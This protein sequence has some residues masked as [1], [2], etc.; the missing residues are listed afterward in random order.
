M[1]SLK[2]QPKAKSIRPQE[3]FSKHLVSRI[4]VGPLKLHKKK[5]ESSHPMNE[6]RNNSNPEAHQDVF[7]ELV[8]SSVA[9]SDLSTS[10]SM[11]SLYRPS[12][13]LDSDSRHSFDHAPTT[14]TK[15]PTEERES[16]SFA[17][18]FGFKKTGLNLALTRTIST[19]NVPAAKDSS[20]GTNVELKDDLA[21]D[22]HLI[23]IE[24]LEARV[25]SNVTTGLTTEQAQKYLARDGGNVIHRTNYLAKVYRFLMYFFGGFSLILWPAAIV[26]VLSYK[27]FGNPNP[28]PASLGLAIVIFGV[29][30]INAFFNAYQDYTS[31]KVMGAIGKMM[32]QTAIVIRNGATAEIPLKDVAVG[33]VVQLTNGAKVPADCRILTT[34]QLKVDASILTGEAEPI[35]CTVHHTDNNYMETK[36]LLFMGASIVEGSGTGLV[37][38][39]GNRTVMGKIYKLSGGTATATTPITR[40]LNI[41]LLIIV[42]IAFCVCLSLALAYGLWLK[43]KYPSFMSVS[44]IIVVIIGAVVGLLPD[45]LPVSITLTFSLIARKMFEHNVM[46]KNLPTVETLGSISVIASDKTGTLTQNK[47]SLMHIFLWA[48]KRFQTGDEIRQLQDADYA[49][50]EL[51]K[52]CCLCNRAQFEDSSANLTLQQRKVVGDASDTA[53][54]FFSEDL[55]RTAD[56]RGRHQKLAEIPFNSKNKWMLSIYAEPKN[57]AHADQAC[58]MFKGAPEMVIDRCSTI[59]LEDGK[60]YELTEALREKIA[61]EQE[62]LSE[63]GERVLGLSCTYLDRDKYPTTYSFDTEAQNFPM[64]G[65]CF[66]GLV[67]LIDPPRE[68]V[69]DAVKDC[70]QAGIRVMMVTGDHPTTAV[71]IARMVGIVTN[72]HVEAITDDESM[73]RTVAHCRNKKEKKNYLKTQSAVV[74]GADIPKFGKQTW[75]D[76]LEFKEIVFARTTPEHKLKIVQEYQKKKHVVAAIG[77]GVNDSPALKQSNVGVAMGSGSDIAREAADIVLTNSKFSSIVAG[78]KLGRVA[79]DNLKKVLIYMLP[80]GSFSELIPVLSNI[81]LGLPT[82]LSSFLMVI[83]CVGTDVFPSLALIYEQGEQDIMKRKPRSLTREKLVNIQVL[84]HAYFFLGVLECSS[85]FAMWF[86]YMKV[87]GG[88]RIGDLFLSFDKYREGFYGKS[89]HE[90]NELMYTGQCIFFVT[91]VMVQLTGNVISTR[92]RKLSFFQQF[93]FSGPSKN[94]KLVTFSFLSICVAFVVIYLPLINR[95]FKTRPIPFQFW[96]IPIGCGML[97]FL[98]DETRKLIA[99]NVPDVV[100]RRIFW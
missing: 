31:L 51:L 25:G 83:I 41:F 88:F 43:K 24:Q 3:S 7:I 46:V 76:L 86:Y 11:S 8:D 15:P 23:S 45:G 36:N 95:I 35:T 84:L 10:N 64:T 98:L 58:L 27:P 66:V 48:K 34:Q 59:L 100:G 69:P 30:F 70:Q 93:P 97:I 89:Q 81:F 60:E 56:F 85:A 14:Q 55:I 4:F 37:V 18:A 33:D 52:T 67:A 44:G 72:D 17:A 94:L 47:M 53:L 6:Q 49:F 26:C 91:L 39:T 92:T 32:P 71:S 1:F 28:D 75:K 80:A 5:T 40:E 82:P 79:F 20:G 22:Y 38:A 65:L 19:D 21:I 16:R 2:V 57:S 54:L 62:A 74:K 50:M 73:A 78:V 42:G 63:K 99:R 29:I 61:I 90:L 13:D 12:L 96:L 87:Y 68:D 77:D 9:N